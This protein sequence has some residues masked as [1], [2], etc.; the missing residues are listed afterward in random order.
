MD[1]PPAPATEASHRKPKFAFVLLPNFT[2][3]P[4]S[5]FIDMLRLTADEGDLSKPVRCE[6]T[7][8]GSRQAPIRSSCGLEVAPWKTY[9]DPRQYDYVVVVGGV[10]HSG[11]QLDEATRHFLQAADAAGVTLI[12]ICTGTFALVAAKVMEDHRCCVSWYH[13]WDF[14]EAFPGKAKQVVADRRILIDRRRITCSGGQAAID[15]AAA[16]LERHFDTATVR[17][18]LSILIVD[19]LPRGSAPQPLPPG[20]QRIAHPKVRRAITLMEQHLSEPLSV[21]RIAEQVGLSP[22]QLE[23]LFQAEAGMSPL[24]YSRR[25]CLH[26]A[27]WMLRHT[28]RSITQ[29]ASECGF[30]GSSHLGR[31][32]RGAFGMTPSQLRAG[33]SEPP[34]KDV[35]IDYGELFPNRENFL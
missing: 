9:D 14:I 16:V 7:I 13:Y 27:V 33:G 12:G 25:L 32:I 34:V 6:W 15:V 20:T 26:S 22:R 3:T 18:A 8:L 17:K 10:L 23:R 4:F 24:A 31:A 1:S 21:A 28:P 11:P 30:A 5:C 2:L 29:I 19:D 35:D